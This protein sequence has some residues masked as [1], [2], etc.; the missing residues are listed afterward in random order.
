[1]ALEVESMGA[2]YPLSPAEI[3]E[4]TRKLG[5]VGAGDERR[6][7]NLVAYW[8]CQASSFSQIWRAADEAQ[9]REYFRFRLNQGDKLDSITLPPHFHRIDKWLP[10]ISN[11]LSAIRV[12]LLGLPGAVDATLRVRFGEY[13]KALAHLAALPVMLNTV[14]DAWHRPGRGQPS[15]K[16]LS[17]AVGLL[18]CAIE[19]YTGEEFP[20][21][22]S[23]KR[24]AE[25][26]LVRLL[27]AQLFPSH[28]PEQINTMLGHVHSE[29]LDNGERRTPLRK[30][31]QL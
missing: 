31:R 2:V 19:D 30:G 15:L 7:R 17:G 14:A 18:T 25:I 11:R 9:V 29:R 4:W 28:T 20:S 8:F 6:L 22:R 13:D 12:E 21:P 24:Q 1:V 16:L 26:E 27:A 10:D 3:T 5:G 23:I